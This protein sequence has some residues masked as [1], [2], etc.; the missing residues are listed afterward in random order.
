MNGKER[1]VS[2]LLKN[3]KGFISTYFLGI[4][5]YI[6]TIV[7]LI[8]FNLNVR[9]KT[10]VNLDLLNEQQLAEAEVIE[11]VKIELF[12]EKINRIQREKEKEELEMRK[13]EAMENGEEYSEDTFEEREEAEEELYISGLYEIT[14][15]SPHHANLLIQYNPETLEVIDYEVYR[16]MEEVQ[17][18]RQI[19]LTEGVLLIK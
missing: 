8:L 4:F 11:K 10:M 16:D 9:L 15:D 14:I 18:E 13:K 7:S 5:L 3:N 19:P 6:T 12:E 17:Y 1:V 2:V